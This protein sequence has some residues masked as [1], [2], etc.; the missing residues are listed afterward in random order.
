MKKTMIVAVFAFATL[1]N[2]LLAQKATKESQDMILQ[3][4]Q[5]ILTQVDSI[6]QLQAQMKSLYGSPMNMENEV[7]KISYAYG[8]SLAQNLMEQGL[9]EVDFTAFSKGMK[10]VYTGEQMEM[11]PAEAQKILNDYLSEIMKKKSEQARA[12]GEEFL[13]EN[14]K[15]EGIT[16]TESGLQYE[17]LTEGSGEKP[18]A[19]TKVTVHYHGTTLDGKVFDSSVERGQPA[20]FGLNQVIPGW[21]EG[22]QLMSKGA[23]YRFYIP[24][25]LA[26]GARGAG[27][28]IGPYQALIFEVELI[29]F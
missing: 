10:D 8:L 27:Q 14:A 3:V 9:T 12:V 16:V 18:T 1:G 23:K 28:A 5:Q 20:T 26:Y 4:Q 15:K 29:S 6:K 21:T 25:D 13:A 19:S 24:T 22:V 7:T 17:V 11:D 2:G